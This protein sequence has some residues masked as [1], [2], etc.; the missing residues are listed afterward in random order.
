MVLVLCCKKDLGVNVH[1][2]IRVWYGLSRFWI[3]EAKDFNPIHIF[4]NFGLYLIQIIKGS[5]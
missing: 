1:V 5:I 3:L 2:S 4:I